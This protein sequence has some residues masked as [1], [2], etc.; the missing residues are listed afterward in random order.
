MH[1]LVFQKKENNLANGSL[2]R[3]VNGDGL[4][5]GGVVSTMLGNNKRHLSEPPRSPNF[6]SS[7]TGGCCSKADKRKEQSDE[8]KLTRTKKSCSG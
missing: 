3:A 4:R 2:C 7:T 1:P 5:V 6:S 8:R